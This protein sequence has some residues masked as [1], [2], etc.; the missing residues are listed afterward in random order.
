[1]ASIMDTLRSWLSTD[2]GELED[3]DV[4]EYVLERRRP[5]PNP[6]VRSYNDILSPEEVIQHEDLQDGEY[7]LQE[8]KTTGTV[9]EVV[10]EEEL[11]FDE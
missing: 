5:K 9:G 8:L 7:L 3:Y 6:R 2:R 11:T 1:M 4:E 10:W